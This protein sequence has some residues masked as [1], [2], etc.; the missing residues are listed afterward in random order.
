MKTFKLLAFSIFALLVSQV[1]A[2]QT[3]DEIVAKYVDAIGGKDQISKINSVYTESSLDVMGSQGTAKHTMLAGKGVKNEINVMGTEVTMCVTDTMGWSINPMTGNYNAEKMPPAQFKGMK[4]DI[5]FA[6]PFL[7]Y[8]TK[9]YKLEL[10]G[11]QTIGTVNA[12]KVL[13]TSPDSIVTEYYFDPA[14]NYLIQIVQ[15][16]DMGG[17]SMDITATLSD[18]RKT[19]QG[20]ALPYKMEA[21]Y[22]GQFFLVYTVTKVDFNQPVDPAIFVKP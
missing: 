7:D 22:G 2:A 4:D 1:I 8:A 21:N 19:D 3:A 9:G 16:T 15:K 17:Q 20:V 18:Y 10:A 13:V 11:Q 14:T 6:G 12:N 5:N